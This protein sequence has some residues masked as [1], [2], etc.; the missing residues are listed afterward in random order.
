MTDLHEN[1]YVHS[2]EHLFFNISDDSFNDQFVC[3]NKPR[4]LTIG[5][6]IQKLNELVLLDV[7]NDES[8]LSKIDPDINLLYQNNEA[9]S[10]FSKSYCNADAFKHEI[11]AKKSSFSIFHANVRT[12]PRILTP[13]AILRTH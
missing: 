2:N 12:F 5:E 10:H 8:I 1:N 9:V 4:A 13:L 3:N 6:R 11:L 7:T